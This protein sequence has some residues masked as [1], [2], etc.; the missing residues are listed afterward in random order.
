MFDLTGKRV[1]VTGAATG[2]GKAIAETLSATGALVFAADIDRQAGVAVVNNLREQ[3]LAA[4]FVELDVSDE[5]TCTRVAEGILAEHKGLDILVN[6]AG[7]GHVGTILQTTAADLDRLFAVNVRGMFSL[8]KAFLPAMIEQNRGVVINMAS[9]GGV[10]AISD[11]LAYCTTKFAV[12]GFTKCLALDH[13]KQGIRAIAVC[14][15]R[16]ETDFVKKRL[17]EY[18]D[19]EKAY[20]EMSSTQ[21]VGRMATSEEIASAVLYLASDEASFVTG[22]AFEIDGGF[23]GI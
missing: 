19:P 4:E 5:G 21:A 12:V 1:F 7:V 17:A 16:V 2:I 13:A 14:P 20:Q 11:R 9:I 10:V 6:N 15:G 3:G 8:T 18:P 22:T 23:S